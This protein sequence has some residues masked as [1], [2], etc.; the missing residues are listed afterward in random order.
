V[1]DEAGALGRTVIGGPWTVELM[2]GVFDADTLRP[3]CEE[4]CRSP[5]ST[6]ERIGSRATAFHTAEG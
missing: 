2:I 4:A 6:R 5:S 1:Q 3:F